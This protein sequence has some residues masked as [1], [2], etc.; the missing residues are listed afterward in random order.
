MINILTREIQCTEVVKYLEMWQ[1]SAAH[2]DGDLLHNFDASV[3][4]LPG[5]LAL[6]HSLEEGQQSG[7]AQ[8][9][10]DN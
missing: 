3:S 7:N 9:T 8:S 10:G 5:F 1:N 4:C 2:E 6:A